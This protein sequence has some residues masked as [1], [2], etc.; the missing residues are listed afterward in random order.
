MKKYWILLIFAAL[1]LRLS[2]AVYWE[3]RTD[4]VLRQRR[5]DEIAL[6]SEKQPDLTDLTPQYPQ[7]FFSDSESYWVLGGALAKGKPYVYG[8]DF[9]SHAPRTPG[10]PL[11]LAPLFWLGGEH[12]PIFWGRIENV[13]F[14]LLTVLATGALGRFITGDERVGFLAALFAAIDPSL[15]IQS[16][17]VL[18]E[19]PFTVCALILTL[20]L[21]AAVRGIGVDQVNACADAD[22]TPERSAERRAAKIQKNFGLAFMIGLA[23]AVTTLIRPVWLYYIPFAV[24]F[25]LLYLLLYRR[26]F[27]IDGRSALTILFVAFLSFSFFMSPW[28]V[29]NQRVFGR[30]VPTTLHMGVSLYDGL[31]P[32]ADGSS[33]TLFRYKFIAEEREASKTLSPDADDFEVRL[34]RRMKTAAVEWAKTHPTEAL[35]LAWVKFLRLWNL[36]PNEPSF[37]SP[38]VRLALLVSFGPVLIFALLGA[39]LVRRDGFVFWLLWIPAVYLSI[40][41]SIFVGSIRYRIPIMPSLM[42]L[43]AVTGIALLE[44]VGWLKKRET[45]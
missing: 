32:V 13:L 35:K 38:P 7:L 28:W 31:S 27:R 29:R 45:K 34:D 15:V 40:I 39:F 19:E 2:A 11:I 12:P 43:A 5:A 30:F 21:A 25:G 41:H 10:Y 3:K 22:S 17:F 8:R 24:C 36:W 4:R 23:G 9:P 37:S 18:S 26:L 16:T 6:L 14:G 1:V 44:Q 33:D 20:F 42:V